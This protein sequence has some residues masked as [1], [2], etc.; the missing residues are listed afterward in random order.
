MLPVLRNGSSLTPPIVGAINRLESNFDRILGDD[1]R[2]GRAWTGVPVAVWDDADHIYVEAELPGMT[3]RDVEI[4]VHDGMLC[5]RP[6]R[7]P[8]EGRHCLYDGR[9]YG[10]FERMVRL[11]EP[12]NADDAQANLE[13]GVLSVTLP[14]SPEAKPKRIAL[15][16]G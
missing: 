13:D 16:R 6:E 3:D 5:I 8:D 10:R 12:V 7:N 15:T 2:A 9:C 14:K 1:G 11:P 4:T